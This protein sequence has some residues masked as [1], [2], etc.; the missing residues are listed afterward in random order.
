M[1]KEVALMLKAICEHEEQLCTTDMV[2]SSAKA[3]DQEGEFQ[4]EDC[5][6]PEP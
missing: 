6:V 1:Q 3:P 2:W 4:L 5:G